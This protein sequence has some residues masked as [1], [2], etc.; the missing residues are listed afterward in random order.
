V[1]AWREGEGEREGVNNAQMP[2][3]GKACASVLGREDLTVSVKW[4]R[5]MLAKPN[6]SS[7]LNRRTLVIFH[8]P[9]R[10]G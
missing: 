3:R 5:L 10:S 9:D 7:A 8:G 6:R 2:G 1:R 4:S